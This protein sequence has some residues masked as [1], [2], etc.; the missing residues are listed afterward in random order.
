MYFKKT[1]GI[2]GG[3][4]LGKMM[5]SSANLLG[6]KTAC[7]SNEDNSPAVI[8][9]HS[10]T[11]GSYDD[12]N[13]ILIF[14]NHCD[15]ITVEFESLNFNALK[16]IEERQK[17]KLQPNA[18][19]IFISQNRFREKSFFKENGIKTANFS[20]IAN[21][22]QA[23]EFFNKNGK[24]LLKTIENGYDG[25]GQFLIKSLEDL[26][27]EIPYHLDLI[28]EEFLDFDFESSIILTRNKKND[29]VIFPVPVNQHKN[30]ILSRSIVTH[31]E[32]RWKEKMR[33]TA[34]T[35]A[36]K[37]DFVGTLAVEFFILKSGEIVVNEMAPRPHNSG[38]FS[39]D[40][41]NVS[42]FENHI[43]AI[44]GLPLIKP[45][46][47]FEGEMINLIG[48]GINDVIKYLDNPNAKLH[49]YGKEVVKENRKMG[50]INIIYDEIFS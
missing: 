26:N 46:L 50:H 44:T 15:F 42:Q 3:G 9:A 23:I 36:E 38:H 37:L 5:V 35:I 20:K 31:K 4:Q 49:L 34:Q 30:G 28:A 2:I 12:V 14:G 33:E 16:Q 22:E 1:I 6:F 17:G 48:E 24:F 41:C 27:V 10:S 39:L 29:I 19:A 18:N 47:L 25:K 21:K 7:Y 40:L 45:K 11:I 43:R 8:Y 13:N 32:A